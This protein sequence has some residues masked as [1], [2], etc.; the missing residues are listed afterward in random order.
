MAQDDEAEQQSEGRR[1]DQEE[2]DR[3]DA[4]G[5]VSRKGLPGLV[6]R[7]PAFDHVLGHRRLHHI[8]T[9]LQELAM[10]ARRTPQGVGRTEFA[11]ALSDFLG[12]PKPARR[13]SRFSPPECLKAASV[14]SQD[15]FR[16]DD[17]H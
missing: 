3:G 16:L 4:I 11:D 2:I 6:G 7:S 9:D 1:G 17:D 14:P 13:S 10:D 15:R 12:N 8:D 5:V